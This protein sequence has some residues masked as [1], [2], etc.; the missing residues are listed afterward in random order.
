MAITTTAMNN[1]K[2]EESGSANAR[3][4]FTFQ[5]KALPTHPTIELDSIPEHVADINQISKKKQLPKKQR[6]NVSVTPNHRTMENI[7]T[8]NATALDSK[9]KW[10]PYRILLPLSSIP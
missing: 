9:R 8:A 10:F 2:Q 1:Q 6:R 7:T 4:C 5:L 3:Q